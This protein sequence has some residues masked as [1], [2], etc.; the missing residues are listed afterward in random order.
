VKAERRRQCAGI[1]SLEPKPLSFQRTIS[2]QAA[3][4]K[5]NSEHSSS[6]SGSGDSYNSDDED[7]EEEET[8]TETV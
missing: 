3:K 7:Q 2:K 8:E 4:F 5:N 6:L 1:G